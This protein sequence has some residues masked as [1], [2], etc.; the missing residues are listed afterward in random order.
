MGQLDGKVALIT[1]G[2]R[3]MGKAH[4][5][6]FL[7][8]GA[9]VVFG[10][11]LEEEGAKLAADLGDDVRFVRMD[12]SKQED[13]ERAAE[14]ATSTFGALNVLV[15]NAGILRHKTI[16]DMT[17]DEFRTILDVNLVGQWLGVKTVTAPMREAGGGSIV[18]VSSTEGF[19]GA[20]GLAAYS[21][22]KFGVRGLT[23]S[24]AREL[25]RY[26]IRVNSIHPGAVLTPLTMQDDIV[27]ATADNADAFMKA[28]PLGRMGK[29]Q[30]V[31]GLIVYLAS[32][33]SSYCT[34][35]EVLVDGGM[36]TGAGY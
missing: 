32:D 3:G 34:G 10:D 1:G 20:A 5:R 27:S 13:W 18:N 7:D 30:E 21:A 36:L 35:S 14:T 22:S 25:G 29:S 12:V 16:E 17:L 15:N 23:K 33:D 8:E 11:V 4:V 24:A 2:A 31:S 6:R 19:I 26:G 9:K 28:L